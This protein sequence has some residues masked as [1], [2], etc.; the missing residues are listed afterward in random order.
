MVDVAAG[1]AIHHPSRRRRSQ[2]RRKLAT[3]R[4]GYCSPFS[5]EFLEDSR[6]LPQ[7]S[8]PQA[9]GG[10][11]NRVCFGQ[12]LS[13]DRVAMWVSKDYS[14]QGIARSLPLARIQSG[15]VMLAPP[16]SDMN[17][18]RFTRSPR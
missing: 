5:A 8:K 16:M 12:E 17:S 18:R 4:V 2:Q 6:F 10:C 11:K 1:G 14:S 13:Q 15:N 7:Q 3:E 9:T